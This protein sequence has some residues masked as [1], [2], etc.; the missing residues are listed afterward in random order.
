MRV[1][2]VGAS[3]NVGTAL[4]RRLAVDAT[5]T[6]VVGVVR[7]PPP[8]RAVDQRLLPPPYDRAEWVGLDIAA[9]GPDAPVVDRLARV[10]AGADAVVHLAWA[11]H[12]SHDRSALRHT[13]VTGSRRV[14]EATVRAGVPH[15]VAAS[16]VGTYSPAADEEPRDE[17]WPTEG[18][19][20][21]SYSVDKVALERLLDEVEQRHPE[22]TVA[23]VR[24]ALVFQ[25]SAARQITRNFLGRLVPSRR[26]DEELPVLPWPRGLRLQA[27]H[28]D[29]VAQAYREIVV[30]RQRGGFNVAADDVVRGDELARLLAGGRLR[31]VEPAAARTA[32]AAAWTARLVPMGPGWLDLAM[33]VPVLD[34]SRARDKLRW[35][36][37]RTTTA[38]LAELLAGIAEGAGTASPALRPRRGTAPVTG[39]PAWA[40]PGG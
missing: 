6:S 35:A 24:S 39:W 23:R 20:S 30:R 38:S 17:N 3:G 31:E 4:L 33:T 16:S 40:R 1:A 8:Q 34:S 7:R 22:L 19:R 37:T 10:L 15:L 25:H 18:V 11:L 14:A 32:L 29:D 9:P 2:I 12:P 28:A 36:P 5:V 13:N 21:S 26:L 27:V